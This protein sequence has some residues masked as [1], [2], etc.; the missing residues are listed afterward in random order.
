[1]TDEQINRLGTYAFLYGGAEFF[2]ASYEN[3]KARGEQAVSTKYLERFSA[4]PRRAKI[5]TKQYNEERRKVLGQ[6]ERLKK[7]LDDILVHFDKS[8]KHFQGMVEE[9]YKTFDENLKGYG[10]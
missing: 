7:L 3:M 4:P 10:E 2:D 6:L 8:D 5:L 9:L 1:M